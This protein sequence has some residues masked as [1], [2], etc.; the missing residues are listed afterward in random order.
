MAKL[1]IRTEGKAVLCE[2]PSGENLLLGEINIDC[3]YCGQGV[4]RIAGHHMRTVA[5]LLAEWIE[6]RG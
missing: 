5:R 6:R 2:F 1:S 3:Q 4:W